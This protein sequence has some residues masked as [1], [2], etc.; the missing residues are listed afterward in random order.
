MGRGARRVPQLLLRLKVLMLMLML[1]MVGKHRTCR[2]EGAGR[3]GGGRLH[4]P[5]P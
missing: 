2:P 5:K 4:C 1:L 3:E